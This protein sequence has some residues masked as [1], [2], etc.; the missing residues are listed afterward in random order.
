[1]VMTTPLYEFSF[2][3]DGTWTWQRTNP[4]GSTTHASA[5]HKTMGETAADAFDHGFRPSVDHWTLDSLHAVTYFAPG[6]SPKTLTKTGGLL[7][8]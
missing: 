5:G 2:L 8:V 6:Q 3:R 1:M 7:P 4:D